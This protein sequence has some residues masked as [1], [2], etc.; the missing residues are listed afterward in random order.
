MAC[1]QKIKNKT[2]YFVEIISKWWTDIA[3]C[4]SKNHFCAEWNL[5]KLT[6]MLIMNFSM[7]IHDANAKNSYPKPFSWLEIM[8]QI[9]NAGWGAQ[10]RPGRRPAQLHRALLTP[11]QAGLSQIA[12]GQHQPER[13][14]L[15]NLDNFDNC[16]LPV[17][18]FCLFSV[19]IVVGGG[20][21]RCHQSL[22]PHRSYHVRHETENKNAE[23]IWDHSWGPY[24]SYNRRCLV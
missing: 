20:Q 24:G 3:N 13:E 2:G 19:D 14:L 15:L 16:S 17:S 1:Y 9:I 18:Q 23:K 8:T 21:G 7:T 22:R 10:A 5:I 12:G 4:S 6:L 11:P